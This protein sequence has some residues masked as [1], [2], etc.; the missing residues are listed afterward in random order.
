MVILMLIALDDVQNRIRAI[1][2]SRALC[3]ECNELVLPKCGSINIWHWAHKAN[4]ICRYGKG[5]GEWHLGLQN[6]ALDHGA[7][8]EVPF[9]NKAGE[10]VRRADIV[11]GNRVIEIQHSNISQAEIQDRCNFYI[12]N[13][14]LVDWLIDY[15]NNNF[16]D[17]S[18]NQIIAD[19]RHKRSFDILFNLRFGRV[20]FDINN[21]IFEIINYR[22][23]LKYQETNVFGSRYK[24]L[25]KYTGF[26]TTNFI[27]THA[28]EVQTKEYNEWVSEIKKEYLI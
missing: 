9:K 8:V 7:D 10:I 19:G 15:R 26:F 24:R 28:T 25:F 6:F 22:T 3:P 17:I 27:N 1:P 16:L 23:E 13:K 21:D 14:Y 12:M 2:G 4:S 11:F 5:V 20:L 18:R